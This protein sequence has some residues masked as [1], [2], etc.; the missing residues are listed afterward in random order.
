MVPDAAARVGSRSHETLSGVGNCGEGESGT[1]GALLNAPGAG[2]RK[3]S[4]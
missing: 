2:G 4:L 1:P 3:R